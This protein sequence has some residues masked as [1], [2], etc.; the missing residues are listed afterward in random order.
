MASST[1]EVNLPRKFVLLSTGTV[2]TDIDIDPGCR[3][4]L[5]GLGGLC[6]IVAEDGTVMADV[7]L[8]AGITPLKGPQQ[9]RAPSTGSASRVWAIY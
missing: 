8:L 7:P 9:L 2:A 6:T 1:D 4:L 3:G 5:V